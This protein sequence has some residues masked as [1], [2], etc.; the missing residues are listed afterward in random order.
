MSLKPQALSLK[1]ERET[2]GLGLEALATTKS[3]NS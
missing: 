2:C 3:F 1:L